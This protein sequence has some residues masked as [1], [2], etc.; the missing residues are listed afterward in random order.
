MHFGQTVPPICR[1]ILF[2]ILFN[3]ENGHD[4]LATNVSLNLYQAGTFKLFEA[5]VCCETVYPE[6]LD[7][8]AGE[9]H[10]P[11]FCEASQVPDAQRNVKAPARQLRSSC[12]P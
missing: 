3:I 1:S 2:S 10:G 9:L 8:I 5:A 11:T 12:D 4:G 7:H 6:V